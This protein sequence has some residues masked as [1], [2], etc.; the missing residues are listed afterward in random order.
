MDE[1]YE[2]VPITLLH[3]KTMEKTSNYF[4]DENLIIDFAMR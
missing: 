4:K 2:Y 3:K 1:R